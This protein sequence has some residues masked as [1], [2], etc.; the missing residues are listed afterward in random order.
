MKAEGPNHGSRFTLSRRGVMDAERRVVKLPRRGV[1]QISPG[2]A[3]TQGLLNLAP[4][5]AGRDQGPQ[6][7]VERHGWVARFDLRDARLARSHP[8]RELDL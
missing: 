6:D 2:V 7:Q 4:R 3:G 1:N 5:G 8:F